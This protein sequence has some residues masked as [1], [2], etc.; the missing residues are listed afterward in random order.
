MDRSII[1]DKSAF[2]KAF[3][4]NP[5]GLA[6][7]DSD[8]RFLKTNKAFCL[9]LGYNE[10]ELLNLTIKDITHPNSLSNNSIDLKKLISGEITDYRT[11]KQYLRKDG[12]VIWGALILTVINDSD[13]NFQYCLA[14]VENIN[15]RKWIEKELSGS[16]EKFKAIFESNSMATAILEEDTTI[17]MVNKAFCTMSGFMEGDV[18]GKSW[19]KFIHPDDIERLREYNIR[20][21]QNSGDAPQT[22][23]FSFFKKSGETMTALASVSNV[24]SDKRVIITFIDLTVRKKMEKALRKNEENFRAIANYSAS[25]ESWFS[26]E[27]KLIWMNSYPVE[28]TGFTVEEYMQAPDYLFLAIAPE[29]LELVREKF[30]DAMKGSS[31]ANLEF[32]VMRKDGSKFWVSTSWKQMLDANDLSI[33]FRTSAQ[34]ITDR[35]ESVEKLRESEKKHRILTENVSDVIWVFNISKMLPVYISP[36][37]QKLRGYTSEDLNDPNYFEKMHTPDH[38]HRILGIIEDELQKFIATGEKKSTPFITEAQT[39]C[40]NGEII[41]IED[42]N[43]FQYN[44]KNEIELYGVT[45]NIE[46]RKKAENALKVSE[47]ELREINA[48]KDKLFSIIAHD[49]RG[50]VGSIQQGLEMLTDGMVQD[51]NLRKKLLEDLYKSS[52]NT[53]NLLENLLKWSRIQN[54]TITLEPQSLILNQ[55]LRENVELLQSNANLKQ[56]HISIKD[57]DIF[58]VNADRESVNLIIR[59]L[60]SNAIKFTPPHGNVSVMA[61][62]ENEFIEVSVEDSGVGMEKEVVEGILHGGLFQTSFGTNGEKGAGLGLVLCRDFIERNGGKLRVESKSGEGSR[63]IFTLPAM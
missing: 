46:A 43:H 44:D 5:M 47:S 55:S 39:N 58:V 19:T 14:T 45:R 25:W 53:H 23:E 27:G 50:P 24:L 9:M 54:N 38:M 37:N 63:F 52:I 2:H 36:S 56:I 57:N 13:G 15:D 40:K 18:I 31:G 8:F 34:D 35:K 17:V 32:R 33:G 16:E 61:K 3:D 41:W 29:D 48:T 4:F 7:F 6:L 11:E 59:N 51:E 60:I 22:Y 42:L 49:L 1:R 21:L 62:K 10:E 12:Q 28:L 30:R 26:P 20:R